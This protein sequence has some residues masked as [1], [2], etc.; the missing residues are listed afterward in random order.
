MGILV[1]ASHVPVVAQLPAD[2]EARIEST[3]REVGVLETV[4]AKEIR[5]QVPGQTTILSLVP[6]GT[7]VRKGDLLVEFDDSAL[8]DRLAKSKIELAQASAAVDLAE[9]ALENAKIQGKLKLAIARQALALVSLEQESALGKSGS[10]ALELLEAQSQVE[11]AKLRLDAVE[12]RLAGMEQT[13]ASYGELQVVAKETRAAIRL[14]EAR[15]KLLSGVEKQRLEMQSE[16]AIAE[17][18]QQL[19]LQEGEQ[20]S[21][22][23]DAEA[24]LRARVAAK[25]LQESQ[26]AETKQQLE[27]CKIYAPQAGTVMHVQVASGRTATQPLVDG[28]KVRE[29]QTLLRLLDLS[30]WQMRVFVNESKIARVRVGATASV[31]LN[32]IAEE[33]FEGTVRSV[34][35]T[36]EPSSWFEADVKRYAVIVAIDK[37]PRFV[38][39]GLT[40]VVEI[41][42]T[43]R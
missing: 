11:I 38:R 32:A 33:V 8:R 41:E 10:L 42:S 7:S 22:M 1:V 4:G 27:R 21:Q 2:L 13:D 23:R 9:A 6:E 34:S 26:L 28:V 40:G 29:R 5:C 31:S 18:E 15:Q 24:T 39:V 16:L 36:P 17:A 19:R 25:Q 43:Q 30:Q 3:V 35:N 14:G 37:P 20:L 12:K